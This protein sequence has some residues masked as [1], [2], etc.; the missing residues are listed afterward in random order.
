MP[1][2]A[3]FSHK[4]NKVSFEISSIKK[5]TLDYNFRLRFAICT[6]KVILMRFLQPLSFY[7]RVKRYKQ[8]FLQ[9]SQALGTTFHKQ[10]PIF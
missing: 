5:L 10:V 7:D 6:I 8:K 9:P 3:H 2:H 1:F 4:K